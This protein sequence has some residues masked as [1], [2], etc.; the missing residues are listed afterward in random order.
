MKRFITSL[1]I[2]LILVLPLSACSP[3]EYFTQQDLD[4]AYQDGYE[5]GYNDGS[6]DV[7]DVGYDIG[8]DFG[9]EDGSQD[10]Y[11]E[12]HERGYETGYQNGF[13][14][15][16]EEAS[17]SYQTIAEDNYYQG[18][19]EGYAD[20]FE[21]KCGEAP[22]S[23]LF[24]G[25]VNS[26]V[27]HYPWC[28]WAQQIYPENEIWFSSVADAKAHGYRPCKV[29]NPPGTVNAN[30]PWAQAAMV[31]EFINSPIWDFPWIPDAYK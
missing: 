26:D 17:G 13:W 8:Y 23:S 22:S 21:A 20:G 1:L 3:S 5:V 14:D 29:C 6:L 16:E 19:V 30:D 7:Y 18:Y 10:A 31:E 24:V 9:Y 12:G 27:Y 2:I 28:L 11:D 4:T 25:S 15:G